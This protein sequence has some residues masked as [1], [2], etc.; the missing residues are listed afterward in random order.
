MIVNVQH[1]QKYYG[2]ELVLSDVTFEIKEG[3]KAG[4]I[5]RNGSGKTTMLQ[6]LQGILS[7][8][9]GHIA[10]RKGTKIGCLAQNPTEEESFTVR[11]VLALAYRQVLEC[12]AKMAGLE[13]RMADEHVLADEGRLKAVLQQYAELQETF[14]RGGGYE[15]DARI[16]RVA[17]GLGIP[18]DQYTRPFASLSGGEKTKVCLASLLLEQSS[19]LLLDEPTNHLDMTAVEWLEEYLQAYKGT[20][21]IV[22]HDRYFLDRI[23]TK[24]IEIE[25][26]EAVTYL[27][28]YTGYQKEKQEKLLQQFA[29]YQDQQKQIKQMQ[30]SIKRYVEWGRIGGNEKFFRRAA[31]IRKA[32]DR[33]DK[34]KRP[35]LERKT[36]E[37]KLESADRSG[38]DVLA[39]DRVA[40]SFG[41][42]LL[43][44]HVSGLLT[45]GKRVVLI[46]ANGCGK[47]TLFKLLL[48]S[49]HPDEGTVKLG[50]RVEI[51]YLEQDAT[52][53][54]RKSVLDYFREETELEE[55]EARNRLARYLFYGADVFRTVANLS[56]GEWTRLRLALLM[57]SMPN[58]LLLDEPTNHLDIASREEL[59]DALEEFPGTVLAISHD[60]YF[61]NR[62]AGEIWDLRNCTMTAFSGNFDDYKAQLAKRRSA[63]PAI[64]P[65]KEARQEGKELSRNIDPLSKTERDLTRLRT[66][67]EQD[68]ERMEAQLSKLETE[69]ANPAFST[70]ANKLSALLAEKDLVQEELGQRY[71]SWLQLQEGSL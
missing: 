59:E 2:A 6:L 25:D 61:I 7:P 65:E 30:E 35:V 9:Q 31:S 16:D 23:V 37:F 52:S 19:L 66:Q 34:V 11:D 13:K 21:V 60:R 57:H 33:M 51:G 40:K 49:E 48:G 28:D 42:H 26:G 55:G 38:N 20:C 45:Y 71:E 68:I 63:E 24:V 54:I 29:D 47:S 56:G 8:D 27:T 4:L 3:E 10:I 32:L 44:Q 50:S 36:A 46:G 43:F 14:D 62:I 41:D 58:L 5:G 12:Q 22:S 69:L 1:V 67:L 15:M 53:Q 17:A 18:P 64:R 70:D 39:L